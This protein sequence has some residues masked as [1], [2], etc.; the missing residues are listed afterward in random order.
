[1]IEALVAGTTLGLATGTACLASCGPVYGAYLMSETRKGLQSLWVLLLLNA[2]RFFAYAAFGAIMGM[3]GGTMPA[4]VRVPLAFTGYLLFSAYMLLSVVRIKKN[5]SG[6]QTGRFLKITRNP[7][8]LG[9]LTGLSICPAFLIALTSAFE[10]SGPLSGMMYF[11]GFFAGTTVYMLPFA[12]FGLLTTKDWI[13]K[14]ARVIAVVVAIYFGAIGLK[15]LATWLTTPRDSIAVLE[16]D[17]D[18]AAAEGVSIYSVVDSDTLYIIQFEGDPEDHGSELAEQMI[19][20]DL[21]PLAVIVTDSSSW[22]SALERVPELSPVITSYWVDPR[23]G[24]ELL[25]WQERA[26]TALSDAGMRTF[27]VQYEPYCA[28]RVTSVESFLASYSFRCDPDSGFSFLMLNTLACAPTDCST[29]P[30]EH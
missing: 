28:D 1:M 18:H 26:R 24:I 10:S 19:G 3:F 13:T 8:V 11:I 17:H 23:S 30:I 22:P 29:C 12:I 5:C 14:A 20:T 27:A 2:G 7:F 25:P 6:C 4:S 9:A 16:H 15:G 21:P